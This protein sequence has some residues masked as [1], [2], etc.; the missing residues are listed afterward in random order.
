VKTIGIGKY[1]LPYLV[2]CSLLLQ[3]MATIKGYYN[4]MYLN[5]SFITVAI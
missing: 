5:S 2:H 3:H 4:I 1:E